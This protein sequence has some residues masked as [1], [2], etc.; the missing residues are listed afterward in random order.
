MDSERDARG[1]RKPRGLGPE[2]GAQFQ[3]ES[4]VEAYVLRPP[5]PAETFRVLARLLGDPHAGV[6]DLGCGSGEL[7]IPLA[8]HAGWVDA[9]DPAAAMLRAGRV[10]AGGDS[11]KIRWVQASA[12][13]F[14]TSTRYGL[15]VAGSSFHWMEWDAV[16]ARLRDRLLPGACLALVE[17]P[18][19][20]ALPWDAALKALIDEYST[21]REYQPYVL[22]DE[23]V[24]RGLFRV[25]GVH[26]TQ[27]V[28]FEQ[29]LADHVELI[30]SRNGFSRERMGETRAAALDRA[31][32]AL[33]EAHCPDGIV[34][35]QLTVRMSWG[36]PLVT[37]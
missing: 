31:Y 14:E 26:R 23:L 19:F 18:H 12:E 10:R 11:P 32:R 21:N 6:L 22:V 20:A 34:R 16:M 8:E 2:Y 30:H 7:T 15:A 37:P 29:T 4:V 5:Y 17:G 25:Q 1:S 28:P 3:D 9:I 13:T 35:T 36:L 24:A 27:P 33:L